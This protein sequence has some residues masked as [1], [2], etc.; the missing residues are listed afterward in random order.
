MKDKNFTLSKSLIHFYLTFAVR[1]WIGG[2]LCALLASAQDPSASS[3][4]TIHQLRKTTESYEQLLRLVKQTDSGVNFKEFRLAYAD[5]DEYKPSAEPE[6]RSAMFGALSAKDYAR[7]AELA[8]AILK[9]RYV[10]I[11]GHQVAAVAYR[12][13]GDRAQANIH[14]SLARELVRSIVE[15]GDGQSPE[16]AM[17]LISEDEESVILQALQLKMV[18]QELI[19]VDGHTYDRVDALDSGDGEVTLYFN[20]DVP[21]IK[22]KQRLAA[23]PLP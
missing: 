5:S 13:L 18:G 11:Y 20:L 3:S 22:V 17:Q 7:A 4:P 8:E 21:V 15:S 2:M 1:V 23:M 19:D 6:V 12:E 14:G 10:D 9:D 16:S